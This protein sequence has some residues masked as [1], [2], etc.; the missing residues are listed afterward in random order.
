MIFSSGEAP[1]PT[2]P[3]TMNH[4]RM[5]IKIGTLNLCLGLQAKKELVKQT[6]L[7]EEI[8]VL[9]MQETESN[10]NLDHNLLSFPGF[11]IET[12]K[13]TMNSKVG[14]FISSK[15]NSVRKLELEGE[16]SN[17]VI[18]NLMGK[19]KCRIINVYRSFAPQHGVSQRA[20]LKK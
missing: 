8:D 20:K 15:I 7:F 5:K 19:S 11:T 4:P 10:K 13:N 6:I 1:R 12:E 9:C 2:N 3:S 14:I 17:L 16:D 18:I